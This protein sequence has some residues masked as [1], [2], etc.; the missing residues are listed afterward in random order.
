MEKGKGK[1]KKREFYATESKVVFAKWKE[2]IKATIFPSS[3]GISTRVKVC[4][5]GAFTNPFVSET[6]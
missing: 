4:P 2:M 5:H 6:F 3:T 1:I